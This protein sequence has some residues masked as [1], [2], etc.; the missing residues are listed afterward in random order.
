MAAWKITLAGEQA[1]PGGLLHHWHCSRLGCVSRGPCR[2]K[3]Y[4]RKPATGVGCFEVA[5]AASQCLRGGF[6]MLAGWCLDFEAKISVAM[7]IPKQAK[8]P[9][10]SPSA[11]HVPATS[12]DVSSTTACSG[13]SCRDSK[14]RVGL[15]AVCIWIFAAC[16]GWSYRTI[17]VTRRWTCFFQMQMQLFMCRKSSRNS[18]DP[19]GSRGKSLLPSSKSIKATTIVDTKYV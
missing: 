16:F 18:W 10:P 1:T 11:R 7:P 5:D 6:E 12:Y 8:P 19:G 15:S 9:T 17:M 4:I 14:L 3:I 2:Q 13:N